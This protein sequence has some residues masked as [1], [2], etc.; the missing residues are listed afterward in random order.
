MTDDE[1]PAIISRYDRAV[2]NE[3]TEQNLDAIPYAIT[4]DGRDDVIL[5]TSENRDVM[6]L[7]GE[8]IR[9][10]KDDFVEIER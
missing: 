7:R 9:A 4:D 3:P 10:T 2:A 1:L 6:Q 8:W 5:G